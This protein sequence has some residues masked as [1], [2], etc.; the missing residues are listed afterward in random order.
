METPEWRK[1]LRDIASIL[2]GVFLLVHEAAIA[3]APREAVMYVGAFLLAGPPILRV[4][5]K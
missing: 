1:A 3:E 5:G 2:T 4:F